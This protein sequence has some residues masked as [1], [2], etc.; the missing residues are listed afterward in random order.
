MEHNMVVG[1]YSS[2][3]YKGP[4]KEYLNPPPTIKFEYSEEEDPVNKPEHYQYSSIQPIDVIDAWELD[5]YLGSV[6]KY[7]SRF[8]HKG[9]PLEDLCK[10]KFYLDKKIEE[11]KK[12]ES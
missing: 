12:N 8:N 3:T 4:G 11:M 2:S 5:F 1:H 9:K 10:A 7:I 6:I